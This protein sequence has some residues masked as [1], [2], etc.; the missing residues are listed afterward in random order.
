LIP[1]KGTGDRWPVSLIV[2]TRY[3]PRSRVT[4]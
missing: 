3:I 2:R 4:P 1:K